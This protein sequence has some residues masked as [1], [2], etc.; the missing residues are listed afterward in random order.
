MSMSMSPQQ[1]TETTTTTTRTETRTTKYFNLSPPPRRKGAFLFTNTFTKETREIMQ[2]YATAVCHVCLVDRTSSESCSLTINENCDP[3]VRTDLMRAFEE[4]EFNATFMKRSVSVPVLSGGVAFGTWQ[5]LYLCQFKSDANEDESKVGVKVTVKASKFEKTKRGEFVAPKRGCHDATERIQNCVDITDVKAGLLNVLIKHTSASLTLN[6]ARRAEELEKGLNELI[7][8]SWNDSFLEH[9]ME[10]PDDC[11]AHIKATILGE[12]MN[13]PI[14]DGKLALSENEQIL[15][16]EHRNVGGYGGGFRR[17]F[18][19]SVNEAKAQEQSVVNVSEAV[20]DFVTKAKDETI[21]LVHVF[22]PKGGVFLSTAEDAEAF[23]DHVDSKVGSNAAL[24]SSVVGAS[25]MLVVQ[26]GDGQKMF[27]GEGCLE[28]FVVS[29]GD[30]E[31]V[32]EVVFTA[33]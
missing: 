3:S 20:R 8:E 9:T 25:E 6:D 17:E 30:E 29:G 22:S 33:L 18:I 5:G 4:I 21:E 28:C 15:L 32:I 13:V 16:C 24:K 7:P 10:G 26:D 2:N 14:R 31:E 19:A 12:T 1:T 11:P 23:V 27:A